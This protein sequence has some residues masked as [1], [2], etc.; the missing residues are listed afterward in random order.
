MAEAENKS[1]Y[2]TLTRPEHQS[3]ADIAYNALVNAIINQDFEPGAQLSIDG[4][5]KQ[6]AMS[7]TPVREALM[8][9]N[10]ERL[11]RQKTNHGFI[12]A[13]LLTPAEL[14]QMFEL[15]HL[16]ETHALAS[17]ELAND[18]IRELR[19]LVERM[20]NTSNGAVY[21]DYKDYLLLD[22]QLH[23]TL[24]GM[25]GNSFILKA[26]EDLHVHLHLSRLYTGIGLI[27]GRDS[28]QEHWSIVQTLERH[29]KDEAVQ[30]LGNHIKQVG[31][32]LETFL[33][34]RVPG[35]SVVDSVAEGK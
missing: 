11:V 3:L 22:H 17:S 20:S 27:D 1:K 31:H 34:Q 4:L 32:R 6:L 30:L 15:R 7:N 23:R 14:H 8:R 19:N 26:W 35:S 2:G 28:L 25:Q 12:V 5:A 29:E 24:V 16:L 9:A 13:N 21:S 18:V 33:A 10:G